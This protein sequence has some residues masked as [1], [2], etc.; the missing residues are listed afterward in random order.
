MTN[1]A[2]DDYSWV[3][4]LSP[5]EAEA[6][7]SNLKPIQTK[8]EQTQSLSEFFKG[9]WEVLE[10]G[11][12]LLWNWHMDT[13][14]GY[15]EAVYHRLIRRLIINI[16]PGTAKSLMAGVAFPAWTWTQRPSERFLCGSNAETLATRDSLKM[17][18]LITSDWYQ[19][20]W[21]DHVQP[22]PQQWE[23]TLFQNKAYGHRESQGVLGKVTGKRGDCL[24]WDDAHDTKSGESDLQRKQVI[25]GWDM[26]WANRLN[27]PNHSA[28]II[29]MQR[30]HYEDIAGYILKTKKEQNWKHLV[31]PMEYEENSDQAFDAGADIGRPELNDPRTKEGELLMPSRFNAQ[32]VKD[33]QVDLGPY[34]TAGQLQQRPS[35]RGGGEF[36]EPWLCHYKIR[37]TKIP[38][39]ILV[40]P[41]GE[42]KPGVTGKRDNTAMVVIGRG[43]DGNYY[44]LDAY[45]DRL[46]LTERTDK[47]FEWLT[48]YKRYVKGVGYE[49]Y[50]MQSDIAHIKDQMEDRQHRF[51]ITPLG[52][53]MRKEDRIRRLIPKWHGGQIWL[54]AKGMLMRTNNEG[55][56]RDIIEDFIEIEYLPFP[57]GKWDD[58]FDIISRI[59]DDDVKLDMPVDDDDDQGFVPTPAMTDPG[60]GY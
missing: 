42:R 38:V 33:T 2:P 39:W 17:R 23:K 11:K 6:L 15:L 16:P 28:S 54:P 21:G 8:T 14:C 10:P 49:E 50:G 59:E 13:V 53:S 30:I 27:D 32:T 56:T 24:I 1:A 36:K 44:L 37:P 3:D 20:N 43:R 45:R 12:E 46:N 60:V 51:K 18:T 26:G 58:L 29:I 34:G 5:E 31:I 25:D 57:V 48:K 41:A 22:N 4:D 7:L 47:L 19:D 52:G 40:D 35:P 9:A 55:I